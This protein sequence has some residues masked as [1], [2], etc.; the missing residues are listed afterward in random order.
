MNCFRRKPIRVLT[1]LTNETYR[2]GMTYTSCLVNNHN[3]FFTRILQVLFLFSVRIS[4]LSPSISERH[5]CRGVALWW[6]VLCST[7]VRQPSITSCVNICWRHVHLLSEAMFRWGIRTM[8][9]KEFY[10][11]HFF[12]WCNMYSIMVKVD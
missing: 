8:A 1:F 6:F 3:F 5:R 9:P 12:H 11:L 10:L 2:S 4:F 7:L